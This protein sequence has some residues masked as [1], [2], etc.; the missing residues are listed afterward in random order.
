MKK[1]RFIKISALVFIVLFLIAPSQTYGQNSGREGNFEWRLRDDGVE[2]TRYN[3]SVFEVIIPNGV[4]Q[5]RYGAFRQNQ[6]T[7]VVLPNSIK[8][9][10]ITR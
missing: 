7:N 4:R 5:I 1:I 10:R 8:N 9:V 3:G 2:I 6:L